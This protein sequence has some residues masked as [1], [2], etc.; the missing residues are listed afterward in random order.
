MLRKGINLIPK[1]PGSARRG[2]S[3]APYRHF[4]D[5]D[6]LL[7]C[8]AEVGCQGFDKV[9]VEAAAGRPPQEA[10]QVMGLA[11]LKYGAANTELDRYVR[12]PLGARFQTPKPLSDSLRI[13][14]S[15][16]CAAR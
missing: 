3:P 16:V 6:A 10:L 1:L 14:P 15:T 11:Y 13:G 8:G 4:A 12:L 2:Q 7:E 5:R 9:H